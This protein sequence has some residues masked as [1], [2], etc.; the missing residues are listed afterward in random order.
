LVVDAAAPRNANNPARVS[1]PRET[2]G[3]EKDEGSLSLFIVPIERW[4]I[5]SVKATK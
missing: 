2:E 3:K 5:S 1:R 4:E